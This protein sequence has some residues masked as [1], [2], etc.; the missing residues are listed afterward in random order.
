MPARSRPERRW[1]VAAMA[2]TGLLATALLGWAAIALTKDTAIGKA[3]LEQVKQIVAFGPRPPA[4]EA[5]RKEEQ[6]IVEKLRAAGVMVEQ[7]RFSADTPIGPVAMNNIVGRIAGR[8]T[9]SAGG[10]TIILATHYD[11]KLERN[12]AFV[13]AN[14][15]GSGTGLLLALAPQLVKRNYNHSVWLVFLDGEE[16][17][18]NWTARDSVYGSRRFAV[19]LKASGNVSQIGAFILLDMIG[20]ADLGILRDSNS[21]PW[22]AD[23]VW[24]AASKLGYSHNFLNSGGAIEDDHIPL[25]Q[26]GVPSLD[27]IDFDYGRGNAY[28]H[29]AEDTLDKLSAQSL[30]IVGEVVLETLAELDRK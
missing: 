22:L 25:I 4:S 21:T 19:Q 9:G 27:L 26:A 20:D 10:R 17:F 23:V 5:H 6:A 30:Q 11:T 16:A 13:G 14:D 2:M 29:T 7:D 8:G 1:S 18:E 15:G 28:W 12:F 24:K 3:A